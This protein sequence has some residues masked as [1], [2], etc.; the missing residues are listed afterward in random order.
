MA[1]KKKSK[2]QA[3]TNDIP[4]QTSKKRNRGSRVPNPEND[5]GRA[6]RR[7]TLADFTPRNTLR[8]VEQDGSYWNQ[9]ASLRHRNVAFVS[10][11]QD[12]ASQKLATEDTP[13]NRNHVLTEPLKFPP[14]SAVGCATNRN[15]Q[16]DRRMQMHPDAA[17]REEGVSEM[18]HDDPAVPSDSS[19]EVIVFA[20]RNKRVPQQSTK[21]Q[22]QQSK[23]QHNLGTNSARAVLDQFIAERNKLGSTQERQSQGTPHSPAKERRGD[24]L[25]SPEE[26]FSKQPRDKH[27]TRRQSINVLEDR[28]E[29]PLDDYIANVQQNE[30]GAELLARDLREEAS[31]IHNG[32]EW[33]PSDLRDFDN[34]STSGEVPEA[35]SCVI[36]ARERPSGHQY[37]VLRSNQTIDEARWVPQSSLISGSAQQLLRDFEN[38]QK[39]SEEPFLTNEVETMSSIDLDHGHARFDD[40]DSEERWLD[41]DNDDSAEDEKDLAERRV[42][43]RADEALARLLAKQQDLGIDADELM[44]WDGEGEAFDLESDDEDLMNMLDTRETRILGMPSGSPLGLP[45]GQKSRR[46]KRGAMIAADFGDLKDDDYGDFDIMD[47]EKAN[48][49]T[50]KKEK[51]GLESLAH[52]DPELEHS[53]RATWA[54]DRKKKQA[55][56][57]EREELR[58]MGLLG[59]KNVRKGAVLGRVPADE[60]TEVIRGQFEYFLSGKRKTYPLPAMDKEERKLIH[61]LAHAFGIQSKSAGKGQDRFPVLQRTR[62][63]GRF[64]GDKFDKLA[65]RLARRF[66]KRPSKPSKPTHAR[67]AQTKD[68]QVVGAAAPE[69]ESR[70]RGHAMLVK[71]GWNKGDALGAHTNK[72]ILQPV[73]SIVKRSRSGLG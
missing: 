52:L 2:Q 38:R 35:F 47:W 71:M 14:E 39:R 51:D 48:P 65:G 68:G 24:E 4:K 49:V 31:V 45:G 25:V 44:I 60:M 27:A 53:L 6:T 72:G 19:E 21:P 32:M 40:I 34:L 8:A 61:E 66:S 62:R 18:E 58:A 37:L 13:E 10:E 73:E 64:D 11:N 57:E 50:K 69:I 17:T 33:D 29:N 63:T 12:T 5:Q 41:V 9:A 20:G 1:R 15:R 55:K 56:K 42:M 54:S 7:D 30:K 16:E 70:N 28:L 23:V 3:K 67:P 22:R 26:F 59:N 36:A 46:K 43:N